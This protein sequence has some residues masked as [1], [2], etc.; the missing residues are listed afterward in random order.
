MGA[1][2]FPRRMAMSLIASNLGANVRMLRRRCGW[3]QADLAERADISIDH[4]SLVERGAR[5][6]SLATLLR[7]ADL[8]GQ[9]LDAI[10][11]R[12]PAAD[13]P[14]RTI[15]I[16]R[17]L[18]DDQRQVVLAMLDGLVNLPLSKMDA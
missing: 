3:S 12:N 8:F 11:G 5:V 7:L 9:P 1:V 2:R 6:P 13:W 18:T 10:V 16:L 4:V 17:R 14:E 15:A